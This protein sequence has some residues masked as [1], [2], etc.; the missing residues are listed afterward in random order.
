M[1]RLASHR[2]SN[3]CAAATRDEKQLPRNNEIVCFRLD[4]SL[5][6]VVVAPVMTDLN[7]PGGVDD[8]RKQPKGNL[9]V[10]GQYFIWTSNV[11]G[12]RL[13]AFVVKVPTQLLAAP[14][15]SQGPDL[16]TTALSNP[17]AA[18]APGSLLGDRHGE[19]RGQRARGRLDEPVLSVAGHDEGDR[20]HPARQGPVGAESRGGGVI[21]GARRSPSR[22]HPPLP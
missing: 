22:F 18:A 16:V 15:A 2:P 7:A 6:V 4:G 5:Q 13:D 8:Y 17:P 9:D 3:S 1:P 21:P 14:G 10:T 19:E 20:R 11:G 12:S